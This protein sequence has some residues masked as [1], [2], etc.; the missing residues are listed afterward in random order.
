MR[1]IEQDEGSFLRIVVLYES[2]DP[3]FNYLCKAIIKHNGTI[4]V[5]NH[6]I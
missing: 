1:L 4:H 2:G 3:W 6:K 5:W